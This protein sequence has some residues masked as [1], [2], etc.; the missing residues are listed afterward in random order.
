MLSVAQFEQNYTQSPCPVNYAKK[1][2]RFV[3]T[4]E[5]AATTHLVDD[6]DEQYLLEKML[7]EVKPRYRVGTEHMHYLLKTPFRYPPLKYGSRFGTRLSPSFFYASESTHTVLA[8]VAYYRFVFLA[9]MQSAYPKPIRSQHML[10]TITLFSRQCADLTLA[11]FHA[12]ESQLKSRNNYHFC[13]AVGQYLQSSGQVDLIRYHS[14]R[15]GHGVNVAIIE[16]KV[17]VSQEPESCQNWMCLTASD[18]VSFTQMGQGE[19]I[20]FHKADFMNQGVFPFPA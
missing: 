9:H 20:S 6:L 14:A 13:Q 10:F 19:P 1:V 16:P 2:K 7:D 12:F 15:S 3:E 11:N 18:K 8:E 17:I 4:Q 5:I